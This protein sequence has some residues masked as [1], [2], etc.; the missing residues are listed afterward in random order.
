MEKYHFEHLKAK[1]CN[2]SF[3]GSGL[4]VPSREHKTNLYHSGHPTGNITSIKLQNSLFASF[5]ARGGSK[6]WNLLFL[7]V[8]KTNF[9]GEP[10][11]KTLQQKPKSWAWRLG[12]SNSYQDGSSWVPDLECQVQSNP[13]L[14]AM[15]LDKLRVNSYLFVSKLGMPSLEKNVFMSWKTRSW[16]DKKVIL[17]KPSSERC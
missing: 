9:I 11:Q 4:G 6:C 14:G 1:Y 10:R 3:L 16:K 8:A 17:I 7:K 15:H 5:Q 13:E 2:I 12:R